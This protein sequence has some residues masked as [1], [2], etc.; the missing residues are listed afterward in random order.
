MHDLD[1][2]R[3]E[4]RELVVD[5]DWV[6]E[7]NTEDSRTLAAVPRSEFLSDRTSTATTCIPLSPRRIGYAKCRLANARPEP[8][9]RWRSNRTAVPSSRNSMTTWRSH[10]PREAVCVHSPRLWACRRALTSAVR[11]T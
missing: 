4:E 9:F 1:L 11:P 2:S 10:G 3:G 8:D 7:L 6:Y 5:H